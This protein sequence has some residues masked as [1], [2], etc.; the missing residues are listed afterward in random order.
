MEFNYSGMRAAMFITNSDIS[1]WDR[2]DWNSFYPE[3]ASDKQLSNCKCGECPD[4]V[5]ED[6]N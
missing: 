5:S 4:Y 6:W 3:I 1:H 2:E